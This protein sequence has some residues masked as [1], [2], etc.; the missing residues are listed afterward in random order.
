[1]HEKRSC[2]Q[3]RIHGKCSCEKNTRY[4][5]SIL[6]NTIL[7]TPSELSVHKLKTATLCKKKKRKAKRRTNVKLRKH[8]AHHAVT[9][10]QFSHHWT[11]VNPHCFSG[12]IY[13]C[14]YTHNTLGGWHGANFVSF[15]HNCRQYTAALQWSKVTIGSRLV[16]RCTAMASH[17]Q[18]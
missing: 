5:V 11:A 10:H 14:V 6:A 3:D 12:S 9:I 18:M 7:E 1:M 8:A 13:I 4:T 2:E 16:H 15:H 17:Y